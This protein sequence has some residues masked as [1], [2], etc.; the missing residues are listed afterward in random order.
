MNMDDL[1]GGGRGQ[2]TRAPRSAKGK[3]IEAEIEIT[4]EEGFAGVQ[5]KIMLRSRAGE[6]SLTFKVPKGVQG[7]EKIRLAGLGEQGRNGGG[8]GDLF[9]TARMVPGRFSQDGMDLL[10]SADVYP[11]EAAL[12]TELPVDTLDGKIKVKIP[13]GIA[14]DGKIRIK[15]RGY[16]DRSGG[17]GDLFL[18]IRIINP[19]YLSDEIKKAYEGLSKTY[20]R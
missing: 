19:P 16:I 7:G 6:K 20:S 14:S 9:L 15:G 10:L 18:K 3:D 12:G 13:A 2:G 5:K 17:R 1:F 8:A 4:P 11:W